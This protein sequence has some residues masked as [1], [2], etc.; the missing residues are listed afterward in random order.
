MSDR[1]TLCTIRVLSISVMVQQPL[2][3]VRQQIPHGALGAEQCGQLV[4]AG[5]QCLPHDR[6]RVLRER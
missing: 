6:R 5:G 2:K 3:G 1:R 4:H